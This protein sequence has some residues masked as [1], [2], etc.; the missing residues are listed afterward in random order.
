[1]P[2]NPVLKSVTLYQTQRSLGQGQTCLEEQG[3]Q[4]Q[5]LVLRE[6]CCIK[7]DRECMQQRCVSSLSEVEISSKHPQVSGTGPA[8]VGIQGD[9]LVC[10]SIR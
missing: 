8:G 3:P 7:N 9:C 4:D 5:L 10:S 6:Q 1:M 2:R